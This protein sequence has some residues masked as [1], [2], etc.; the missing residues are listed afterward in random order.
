MV[1]YVY[2]AVTAAAVALM[3]IGL[4]R[5]MEICHANAF[6]HRLD[7]IERRVNVVESDTQKNLAD[8]NYYVTSNEIDMQFIRDDINYLMLVFEN[9]MQKMRIVENDMQKMRAE[10]DRMVQIVQ[11][12]MQKNA[13]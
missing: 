7:A 5:E 13:C 8:V 3:A 9:N 2:F 10:M 11:D 1:S 6:N 12:R 4:S